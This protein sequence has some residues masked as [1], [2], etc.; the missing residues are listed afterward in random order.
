MPSYEYKCLKCG[1][2]EIEQKIVDP[3]L[4]WC[5][6]CGEKIERLIS[7]GNFLLKGTGWF[8]DGYSKKTDER[9]KTE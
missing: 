4:E 1:I 2:F 3:K 9:P 8:K 6:T 5:P 7:S